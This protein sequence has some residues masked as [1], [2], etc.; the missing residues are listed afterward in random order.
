MEKIQF[1]EIPLQ[2]DE[3]IANSVSSGGIIDGIK[4]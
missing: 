2:R 1:A 3:V 4:T